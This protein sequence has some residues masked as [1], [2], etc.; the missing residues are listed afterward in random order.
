VQYQYQSAMKNNSRIQWIFSAEM[1]GRT[2]YRYPLGMWDKTIPYSQ[3]DRIYP[4]INVLCGVRYRHPK[5]QYH[6]VGVALHGFWGI[7]P[8]GQFR[9]MNNYSQF[10]ISLVVE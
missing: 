5:L 10:G 4:N 7:N 9:A 3:P 6:S 8:Y 2:Q 1:R